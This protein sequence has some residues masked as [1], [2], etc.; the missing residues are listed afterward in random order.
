MDM[1]GMP[2]AMPATTQK[3]CVAKGSEKDP[4]H[5]S[6]DKECEMSDVKISGN[7]TSWTVKCNRK[8]EVWTGNGEQTSTGDSYQGTMHLTGKS[9][10]RD[11][12]M[13]TSYSGKRLGG[14]CDSEEQSKKA[15]AMAADQKKANDKNMA[16]MCETSGKKTSELVMNADIYIVKNTPCA[17]KKQQ[18]CDLLRKDA[19][20][21]AATYA[22]L[23]RFDDIKKSGGQETVSKACGLNMAATTKAMC[24][25][26]NGKNYQ[27]LSAYCPAE[28]KAYRVAQR[29]AECGRSYTSKD[30]KAALDKCMKGAES[31][32]DSGDE[33]AADTPP[34]HAGK[35][36]PAD[37]PAIDPVAEGAKKLKGM[38]HF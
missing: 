1:A 5:S 37:K 25:T 7:K 31:G 38:F 11:M 23:A 10:K 35:S 26:L 17:A 6:K 19:G 22:Q 18:F 34:A 4:R 14:S 12:N 27:T 24:K 8:G 32:T 20:S 28:A 29:K 9:G 33:E 3:V 21:D 36:K 15:E 2:F 16:E 13:T 30:D